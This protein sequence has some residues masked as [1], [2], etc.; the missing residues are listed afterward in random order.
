MASRTEQLY[1]F[2]GHTLKEV[3]ALTGILLRALKRW[4]SSYGWVKKRVEIG[5]SL[6][7]IRTG[8]ALKNRICRGQCGADPG[9]I[10]AFLGPVRGLSGA[11]AGQCRGHR[12]ASE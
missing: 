5:M 6:L 9:P 10:R 7:S 3:T 8:I 4:C 12:F 11:A 1:C 2:D